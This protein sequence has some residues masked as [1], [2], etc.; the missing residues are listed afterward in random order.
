MGMARA[1]SL[2]CV[3]RG[4]SFLD[5]IARQ[6]LHL[7]R[8]YGATL[9][10]I[11]MNSFRT[12][13]DTRAALARYDDL[14]V[15]GLPLEFLQNKEPKLKVD[16]LTPVGW[17]RDPSMEWCPPG[18]G[19]L[20]TAM[21][22]HRALR[23]ADRRRLPLRLRLQLRQ[24]RRRPGRPGGRLVRR[25]GCAVRDRGG[26]PYSLGPQGR[27]LRPPQGRRPHRPARDRADRRQ[28]QGGA[29]RPGAPQ[30]LLHQQPLVRPRADAP[31][32]RPPRQHPRPAADP[33]RE[34]RRPER[35]EEPQGDPDRDRHGRGHRGVP[36]LA[37]HR[38]RSRPVRAGEDDQ[39][40]AG[41]ALGRLRPRQGL[42]ARPGRREPAV[43]R[44]RRGLQGGRGVRQALPGRGAVAEGG[45]V[46]GRQGRLDLRRAGQGE[47]RRQA[48]GRPRPRRGGRGPRR[49]QSTTD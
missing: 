36:R 23:Q 42:R 2:L 4:L 17:P 20:Y 31:R 33:Q 49:G 6:V 44:P 7:R 28:G 9:P 22:A 21:K 26:A 46:A 47:G 8:E 45:R 40:P 11:F 15:A 18:H 43:R 27:P 1:K 14:A 39:R 41:A 32:A 25:V 29:R 24:P 37:H 3:R 12:S 48:E 34:E 16:D 10:L 19:D 13:A 35:P 30:V 38:G 5:V